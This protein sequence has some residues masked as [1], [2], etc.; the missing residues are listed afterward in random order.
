MFVDRKNRL[1]DQ[2]TT[3]R[4]KKNENMISWCSLRTMQGETYREWERRKI[5][6]PTVF[7]NPYLFSI[8]S[9]FLWG[10][11]K[12]IH[13]GK[14]LILLLRSK[15]NNFSWCSN[16]IKRNQFIKG[17]SDT[18]MAT[19][20]VYPTFYIMADVGSWR[21]HSF[22]IEPLPDLKIL[23]NTGSTTIWLSFYMT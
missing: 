20:S 14:Q 15:T 9:R 18:C 2:E 6:Y 11:F 12:A 5:F 7:M 13:I 10:T 22:Q 8:Q 16:L 19:T 4:E 3:G 23:F 17:M 21:K 1:F